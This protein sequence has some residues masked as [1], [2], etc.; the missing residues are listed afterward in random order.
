MTI[1]LRVKVL[2]QIIYIFRDNCVQGIFSLSLKLFLTNYDRFWM[3]VFFFLLFSDT[4]DWTSELF[5]CF[6]QSVGHIVTDSLNPLCGFLNS[7]NNPK[8]NS[9]VTCKAHQS[10][11]ASQKTNQSQTHTSIIICSAHLI[12]WANKFNFWW[13]EQ[14]IRTV[15]EGGEREG[16]RERERGVCECRE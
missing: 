14:S 7:H 13:R 4:L 10:I 3:N 6:D 2:P 8:L 5:I 1:N 12:C 16:D 9:V 15:C 11:R